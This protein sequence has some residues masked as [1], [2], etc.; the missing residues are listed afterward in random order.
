MRI[1]ISDTGDEMLSNVEI[2]SRAIKYVMR[3]ERRA[4]REPRDVRHA[5]MPYD[6]SSPPRKIEVK[7]FGK[8]A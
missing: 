2:E 5:S 3:L 4:H 8:S 6:I 7:G 1:C